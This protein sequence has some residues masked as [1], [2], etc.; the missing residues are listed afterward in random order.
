MITACKILIN[1][2]K[3]KITYLFAGILNTVFGLSIFPIMMA[4][5]QPQ[6][7]HYNIIITICYPFSIFFAF[8]TNKFIVFRTMG[9]TKS[10]FLKFIYF[11]FV[12]YLINICILPILILI[13]GLS[14]IWA[15]MLFIVIVIVS[16]WFW[17]S[18]ITFKNF[19]NK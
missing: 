17:H 13:S 11:H 3:I 15:Q 18:R 4:I 12:H 8:I 16:G 10:E 1:K 7:I 19:M 9:N 5:L 2:H 14:P 6:D